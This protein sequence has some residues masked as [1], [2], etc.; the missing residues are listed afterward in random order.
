MRD[1][2]SVL[3]FSLIAMWPMSAFAAGETLGKALTSH[4][5][6]DWMA[7]LLL[8]TVSGLVAF[9]N[10]VRKHMEAEALEKMGKEFDAKDKMLLDWKPFAALHMA[11]SYMSALLAFLISE[12]MELGSYMEAISISLAAWIGAKLMDMLAGEGSNRFVALLGAAFGSRA[13]ANNNQPG[14]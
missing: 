8:A 10:R 5:I 7:V 3:Y 12:H 6:A 13:N 1:V 4:S 9:L 14:P 11:G 2:I